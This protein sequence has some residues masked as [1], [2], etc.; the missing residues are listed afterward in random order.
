MSNTLTQRHALFSTLHFEI[1]D[2]GVVVTHRSPSSGFQERFSLFE[3]SDSTERE[4][5]RE[6]GWVVIAVVVALL[7]GPFF[8]D[9][10]RLRALAPAWIALGVLAVSTVCVF[11]YFK[12]S[13][14]RV[15]FRRWQDNRSA[16]V[17]W[18]DKPSAPEFETFY[19]TLVDLIRRARLNPRM[20]PDQ[21]ME[22]Y[23]QHFQF[24]VDEDVVSAEQANQY[25]E[26]K[27]AALRS[28]QSK[29]ISLV[30]KG[31]N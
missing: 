9:A 14:D 4:M 24:L 21:K 28:E 30:K 20:T 31:A 29:V 22:V 1:V 5:H 12:R 15:I 23:T 16:F 18:H 3:L 7:A 8:Q 26:Q 25:L 10:V 2:G 13:W 11:M 27:R 19:A 6:W 17:M